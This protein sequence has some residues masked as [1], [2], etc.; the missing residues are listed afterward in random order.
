M[1]ACTGPDPVKIYIMAG[2]SNMEGPGRNRLF[3]GKQADQA[4][5]KEG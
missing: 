3:K 4:A 5:G 1:I 2:Q